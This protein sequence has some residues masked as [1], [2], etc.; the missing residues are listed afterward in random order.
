M[1]RI[2][3]FV[4]AVLLA[5]GLAAGCAVGPGREASRGPSKGQ[6]VLVMDADV[7][8]FVLT[9]GGLLEPNAEWTTAARG[10]VDAA[11][12]QELAGKGLQ[13]I[14][15][16]APEDPATR[17]AHEQLGKLHDTVASV[18][19]AGGRRLPT[20]NGRLDWTLGDAA[21]VLDREQVSDYA[22]FV[23]LRDSYASA[24]RHAT[25]VLV[26]VLS[27]GRAAIPMGQQQAMASLVDLRTGEV[28]WMIQ[29]VSATG[30]L[31]TAEPARKTVHAL[32][33]SL[34]Q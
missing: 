11:I 6:R 5:G 9:A 3:S 20:K 2:A 21:R 19:L 29:L 32:L 23:V 25:A 26:G 17:H 1:R 4:L 16:Q 12:H 13:P 15:Y 18:V 14:R 28:V 33:G 10:H 30:D 27:L 22:L 24:G 8:L 34:P 31:R 7:Q